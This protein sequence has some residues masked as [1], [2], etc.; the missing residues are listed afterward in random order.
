MK[1]A[2][3]LKI[4]KDRSLTGFQKKVLLATLEIPRGQTRTYAWAARRAGSPG[5][6]RAAGRALAAN[7]YAPE[8]PCHRI[9]ASDGSIGGYSKGAAMKKELLEKEGVRS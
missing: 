4:K 1:Q 5:A 8:V 7:S 3:A 6:C 2:L 9:I